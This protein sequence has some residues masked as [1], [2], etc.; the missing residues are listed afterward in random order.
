M[1]FFVTLLSLRWQFPV[2][3]YPKFY[4]RGLCAPRGRVKK[5]RKGPLAYFLTR[6]ARE[7]TLK[8]NISRS[9]YWKSHS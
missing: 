1:W 4:L 7:K 6:F 9:L 2:S 5:I 8:T 3:K